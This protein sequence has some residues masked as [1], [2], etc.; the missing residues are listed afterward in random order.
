MMD[1]SMYNDGTRVTSFGPSI[2]IFVHRRQ[3][4]DTITLE[5]NYSLI[6]S[7]NDYGL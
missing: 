1:M 6:Q 3:R 7:S 4:A 2:W 5:P